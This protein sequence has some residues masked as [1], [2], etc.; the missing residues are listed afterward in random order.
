MSDSI[1]NPVLWKFRNW[2]V[3]ERLSKPDATAVDLGDGKGPVELVF[4]PFDAVRDY[5]T[6]I[7]ADVL[8]TL[9][10]CKS[11]RWIEDIKRERILPPPEEFAIGVFGVA[12][13]EPRRVVQR[14][15]GIR[16]EVLSAMTPAPRARMPGTP[17]AEAEIRVREW[18]M[19]HA[20]NDPDSITRDAIAEGVGIS[21]GLVSKTSAWKAFRDERDGRKKPM[22]REISLSN[23]MEA[24]I[25][26]DCARQ[27]EIDEIIEEGKK[28]EA[29]QT[30][31]HKRRHGPS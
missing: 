25:P 28:E 6:G 1:S 22:P 23:T 24:V 13:A 5:L 21:S 18:L 19:K 11:R 29:E 20:K 27:D 16:P 15:V 30:R 3:G 2:L 26:A 31:R 9:D 17:L 14:I 7:G 10:A 8:A 12:A 4:V